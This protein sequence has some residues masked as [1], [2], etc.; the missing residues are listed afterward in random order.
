MAWNQ[1]LNWPINASPYYAHNSLPERFFYRL[2]QQNKSS[3]VRNLP[4]W[5][6]VLKIVGIWKA[7]PAVNAAD[8]KLSKS[9][10]WLIKQKGILVNLATYAVQRGRPSA[11]WLF[12]VRNV[13]KEHYAKLGQRREVQL[14]RVPQ[15]QLLRRP[16]GKNRDR[17]DE[18]NAAAFRR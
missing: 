11:A 5:D 14:G 10:E 16:V 9:S 7:T 8:S 3:V 2:S 12:S 4:K 15:H 17:A 6:C 1:T 13:H 18:A